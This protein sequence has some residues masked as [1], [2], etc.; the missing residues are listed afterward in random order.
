MNEI[1]RILSKFKFNHIEDSIDSS[2]DILDGQKNTRIGN[3]VPVG[4]LFLVSDNKSEVTYEN[5]LKSI[6]SSLRTISKTN[7]IYIWLLESNPLLD[8][9]QETFVCIRR[10]TSVLSK[11]NLATGFQLLLSDNIDLQISTKAVRLEILLP[12]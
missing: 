11:R 7:S 12:V 8:Y 4:N 3:L 6:D 1:S 5:V 9:F 2:I 10:E